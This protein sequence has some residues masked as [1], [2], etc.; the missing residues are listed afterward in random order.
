MGCICIGLSSIQST[1][2]YNI[3]LPLKPTM[4]GGSCFPKRAQG[5]EET[6]Q[7][8]RNSGAL[9][10]LPGLVFSS[11]K[12]EKACGGEVVKVLE[13]QKSLYFTLQAA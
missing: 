4:R 13:Q 8:S 11:E 10:W 9:I 12:L 6:T 1:V 3:L 7:D 5:S 2:M